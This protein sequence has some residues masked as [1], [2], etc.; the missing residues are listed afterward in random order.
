MLFGYPIENS[1][2]KFDSDHDS[3]CQLEEFVVEK[4]LKLSCGQCCETEE[5]GR[6]KIEQ[7]GDFFLATNGRVYFVRFNRH[8]IDY[9][10]NIRTLSEFIA[11]SKPKC[12][13][14]RGV[15]TCSSHADNGY[16]NYFD[17][18]IN[19]GLTEIDPMKKSDIDQFVFRES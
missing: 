4:K 3:N 6:K 17:A 11:Q 12:F 18:Q 8:Y 10:S 13:R 5:R 19:E 14:K 15:S 1:A 16:V 2:I 7:D 9:L